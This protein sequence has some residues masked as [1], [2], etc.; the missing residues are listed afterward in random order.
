MDFKSITAPFTINDSFTIDE[1]RQRSAIHY[2]KYKSP[3]GYPNWLKILRKVNIAYDIADQVQKEFSTTRLTR[4]LC[5]EEHAALVVTCAIASLS[6]PICVHENIIEALANTDVKPMET[7][8]YALPFFVFLLPKDFKPAIKLPDYQGFDLN[9]YAA[10]VA[11][12]PDCVK[13]TYISETTICYGSYQWTE[14]ITEEDGGKEEDHILEKFMKNLILMY[15]YEPKYLT[16]ETIKL[17]TKGKGFGSSEKDKPFQMRWL[18]KNYKQVRQTVVCKDNTVDP[19]NKRSVRA[20]W[21]R[22][23]W[24]TVC[25]GPKHKQRRQQWFKP[26]FVNQ[27]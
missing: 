1:V 21:R 10:F 8:E 4:E 25:H 19:D 18:G 23:H 27:D 11:C 26:V 24:H 12:L 14:L 13:V 9:F 7:P 2:Q 22:G 15:M 20:H 17:P 6:P 3:S 16:E 5:Q